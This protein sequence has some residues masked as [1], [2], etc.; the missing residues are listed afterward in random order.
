MQF[1]SSLRN[2]CQSSSSHTHTYTHYLSLT[3]TITYSHT[4][5]R[6]YLQTHTFRLLFLLPDLRGK[7]MENGMKAFC[8]LQK[9]WF[10]FDEFLK[11]RWNFLCEEFYLILI[12]NKS[13]SFLSSFLVLLIW[14]SFVVRSHWNITI[15]SVSASW[16]WQTEL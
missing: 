3:H 4:H 1:L 6:T 15:F 14:L 13:V 2:K 9:F 16:L 12:L 11:L 8:N 5:A 7:F 10:I